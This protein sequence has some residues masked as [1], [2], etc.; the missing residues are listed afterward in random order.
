[1]VSLFRKKHPKPGAKPGTL[2]IADNAVPPRIHTIRYGSESVEE[3]D[4]VDLDELDALAVN[5]DSILWV[6][7]QGLGDGASLRRIAKRFGM[8]LLALEDVV[9]VPQRP[10]AEKY[11]EHLLLI[12]RMVRLGERSQIDLEQVS[13][14]LGKN[15]VLTFQEQYGDVLD[16]VRSRI[17][18]RS[19]LIH[20]H[21]ADYLAYAV[22]D[23]IV[24][25]Y[26]PVLESIGDYL[27][28]LEDAVL[29]NPSNA[30][31]QQ[32]NRYKNRL[33]NLRRSLWP[34]REAVNSLIRD[35]NPFVTDAVR[36]YLR[37]TYDHCVQT[38]EIAEMYREMV[39]GLMNM[40]LSAVANRTNEVMKVLTVVATIFIPLTFIAGIY[41]M[42]F[43]HMPELSAQWAY[44]ILW[45]VMGFTAASMLGFFWSKGW[46]GGRRG[47][48]DFLDDDD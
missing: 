4:V 38:T 39:S 31:L 5:E 15:Y 17:R 36:I 6:D 45:C 19:A 8:H 30:L 7:V 9:N 44:P 16:P 46:L 47:Q 33:F 26:Y 25:A 22:F 20:K 27:E 41:G 29:E 1:M 40:Y 2:V 14:V 32:L 43:E 48:D 10:K 34:Q 37:D 28:R 11:D 24:D 42:N 18:S 23:T 13:I 35:A 21:G 3:A 12:T